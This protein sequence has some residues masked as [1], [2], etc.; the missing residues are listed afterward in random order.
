MAS[1]ETGKQKEMNTS[2]KSVR[3]DVKFAL[4]KQPGEPHA[5]IDGDGHALYKLSFFERSVPPAWLDEIA[6]TLCREHVPRYVH[7]EGGSSVNEGGSV[8]KGVDS[9]EFHKWVARHVVKKVD[10]TF[11][12]N[13]LLAGRGFQ[14]QAIHK[15][16]ASWVSAGEDLEVM[17]KRRRTEA[18]V[19]PPAP[20]VAADESTVDL[21]RATVETTR[22]L[23]S[24]EIESRKGSL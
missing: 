6:A 5:A 4:T 16:L 17:P 18:P 14:A 8:V 3:A 20:T 1:V 21:S 15:A 22:P 7:D 12:Y 2:L 9:L 24:C 10:H 11:R 13:G 23:S 19:P